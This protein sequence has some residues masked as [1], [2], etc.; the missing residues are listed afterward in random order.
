M[1]SWQGVWLST[2]VI[3]RQ[4][5]TTRIES[6]EI[7]MLAVSTRNGNPIGKLTINSTPTPVKNLVNHL[8]GL[9]SS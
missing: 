8:H 1:E 3:E 6:N 7:T 2:Q 9:I 4:D 5:F